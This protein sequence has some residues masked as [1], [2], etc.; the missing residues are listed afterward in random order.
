MP[1][2]VNLDEYS[3]KVFNELGMLQRSFLT[4]GSETADEDATAENAPM[5]KMTVEFLKNNFDPHSVMSTLSCAGNRR[6]EFK[7][8][9]KNV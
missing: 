3:L 6:D 5:R 2:R 1:E 4:M 9:S 7:D 8:I